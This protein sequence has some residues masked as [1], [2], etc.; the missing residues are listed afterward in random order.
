MHTLVDQSNHSDAKHRPEAV[1]ANPND[2]TAT[3][4]T[5]T[6]N[7]NL[8]MTLEEANLILNVKPEDPMEI[9]QKVS[10]RLGGAMVATACKIRLE[11]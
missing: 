5:G 6:I 11:I 9:I 4:T 8:K 10:L 3:G 1:S 7:A 2:K